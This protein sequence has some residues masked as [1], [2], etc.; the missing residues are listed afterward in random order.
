MK[1]TPT[2]DR[3]AAL[4]SDEAEARL[5]QLPG[6]RRDGDGIEKRFQFASFADSMAFVNR[7]AGLAES[8]DHHP[9]ISIQYDRVQLALSTHS[10]GGVTEKDFA[11]AR[12]IDGVA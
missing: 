8:A 4:S 9:D 6:W 2:E 12:Q 10:E 3:L 7:V 5:Q 1:R 11:L